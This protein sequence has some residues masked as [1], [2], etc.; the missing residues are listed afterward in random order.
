MGKAKGLDFQT[1]MRFLD[2]KEWYFAAEIVSSRD[3]ISYLI[4]VE[5][6]VLLSYSTG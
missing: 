5:I 2:K 6:F 3:V 1:L 4:Q